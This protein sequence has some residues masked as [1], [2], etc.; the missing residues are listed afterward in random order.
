MKITRACVQATSLI[1]ILALTLAVISCSGSEAS[2]PTTT[3]NPPADPPAD[4]PPDAFELIASETALVVPEGFS[5][6]VTVALKSQPDEVV[7]LAVA[8]ATIIRSY[9]S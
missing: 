8:I 6:E 2:D 5:G 7:R 9:H 4:P 1:C 3:T